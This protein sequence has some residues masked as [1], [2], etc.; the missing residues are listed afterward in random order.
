MI[1]ASPRIS[2]LLIAAAAAIAVLQ[3]L[4]LAAAQAA[5]L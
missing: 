2:A 1:D 5:G 4:F 3:P